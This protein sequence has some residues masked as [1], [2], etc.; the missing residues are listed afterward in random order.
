MPDEQKDP[1]SV[2]SMGMWIGVGIAIGT[3]IGAA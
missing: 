1:N 3:A 2:K